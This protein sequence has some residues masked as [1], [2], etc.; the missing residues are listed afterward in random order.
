MGCT[1]CTDR[2]S[3]SAASSTSLSVSKGSATERS[4]ILTRS[5]EPAEP[6]GPRCRA[7]S[8][9][10]ALNSSVCNRPV[11][12]VARSVRTVSERARSRSSK[13]KDPGRALGKRAPVR[14]CEC[15]RAAISQRVV[16]AQRGGQGANLDLVAVSSSTCWHN[17]FCL[18]CCLS[19]GFLLLNSSSRCLLNL[20]QRHP[21][22]FSQPLIAR[23]MKTPGPKRNPRGS[24]T[25]RIQV[26][27]RCADH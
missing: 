8:A 2:C 4:D 6:T 26:A 3:S 20:L 16:G 27:R 13:V 7:T 14:V 12:E 1:S 21:S 11:C 9:C 10:K 15:T 25:A 24:A 19:D 5:W 22:V 18:A 23:V 17:R